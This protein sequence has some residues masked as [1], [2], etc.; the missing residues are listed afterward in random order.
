MALSYQDA[1]AEIME[2]LCTHSSHGYSQPNRQGVGTGATVFESI[3]LSDGTVV[4]IAQG[5]RDCSSAVIECYAALGVDCGGAS[6]TG[7]MRRCMTGTGN[8]KWIPMSENYSAQR[9]DI[10]LNET[11]HTAMCLH[12]YGSAQGDILGQFSISE[13][14][15]TSGTRGDQT[16]YESNIKAY[17]NYPW[18]GKLVYCGPARSGSSAPSQPVVVNPQQNSSDL[19]DLSW[20]GPKFTCAMQSQLGTTVDG[21]VSYQP[22]SNHK[23][24]ANADT[25]SW[26]FTSNYSQGSNMVRALQRKIGASVDGWFGKGSVT[27]LQSWLVNHG[28]SVGSCGCDGSMGADTCTA[29]GKAL[30]DGVFK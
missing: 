23:Y 28:Y 17:Y 18:N 7:N 14:G 13:H 19:G 11:H 29:V 24:L 26:Q 25:S 3:T 30:N 12:P 27:K 21:I 15:T 5:D 10:Y 9:G 1:A 4:Q 2:H 22:T 8:F 16:G 20:W 6:Y